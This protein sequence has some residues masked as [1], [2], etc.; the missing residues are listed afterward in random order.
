MAD[1]VKICPKCGE[2]NKGNRNECKKCREDLSSVKKEQKGS[3]PGNVQ[4]QPEMKKICPVCYAVNSAKSVACSKSS[5]GADLGSVLP[6][7]ADKVED[8]LKKLQ[9][10]QE[11]SHTPT[12][13]PKQPESDSVRLCPNLDCNHINPA[14]QR[15]CEK[16]GYLMT[17][18]TTRKEAEAEIL[19][20]TQESQKHEPQKHEPPKLQVKRK[21][22]SARLVADDGFTYDMKPGKITVGRQNVLNEYLRP[23]VWVS[24]KHA[25]LTFQDGVLTVQDLDSQ[26]H[27][28]VNGKRVRSGEVRELADGDVLGLGD[29]RKDTQDCQA[30]FFRIELR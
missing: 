25:E 11:E 10:P 20:R 13:S 27:T 28:Y 8:E 29:S 15:Q 18:I 9:A 17:E 23:M 21:A 1:W 12:P 14:S 6:I 4:Q 24:R 30:A 22:V 16:C 5:C 2:V 3:E 19:R 7:P 26:N